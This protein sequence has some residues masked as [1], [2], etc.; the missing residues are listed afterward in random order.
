MQDLP[1][2]LIYAPPLFKLN[3]TEET[4]SDQ[5]SGTP[6]PFSGENPPR[7]YQEGVP[8]SIDAIPNITTSSTMP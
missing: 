2:R 5:R 6:F 8:N 7:R 1:G 4:D 3:V